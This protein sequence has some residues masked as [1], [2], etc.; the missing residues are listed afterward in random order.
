[1]PRPD[2]GYWVD[3][4]SLQ[5]SNEIYKCPHETCNPLRTTNYI[6]R[7][8]LVNGASGSDDSSCWNIAAY[9]D[10]NDDDDGS[11]C[12]SDNLI[13]KEGSRG[14]LCSSC[15]YDFTYS[16]EE[17]GCV[18]CKGS[19]MRVF[20]FIGI[21]VG[22][23][24]IFLGGLVFSNAFHGLILWWTRSKMAKAVQQVNSG[25]L[26]IIWANSQVC[27]QFINQAFSSPYFHATLFNMTPF[28]SIFQLQI[29]QSV[30]WTLDVSFPAPFSKMLGFMSFFSFDFI[31][32][33]CIIEGSTHFTK[34]LAWSLVPITIALLVILVHFT[35]MRV[36][37]SKVSTANLTFQ[38]LLLG[39]LILPP[40]TLKQLQALDCVEVADKRYL[41]VDTSIDCDSQ[42]FKSFLVV[43]S[44]FIT[45]Y[46]STPLIWLA[47][48]LF[49]RESLNPS[50]QRTD[51]G[52]SDK[53]LSLF[54]R[55]Q[56]KGIRPLF[57]LVGPYR[58]IYFFFEVIEM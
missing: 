22:T 53:K 43:N 37:G 33:E 15:D 8:L 29:V 9:S 35:R 51:G 28:F 7:R 20:V 31:S 55:D 23:T 16:P 34:V 41:R 48:L 12:N 46:L 6:Q 54:L 4:R 11:A 45:A 2:R 52:G 30:S 18:A 10:E 39:Y 42:E 1:M 40:V 3:R 24:I 17:R 21:L 13:C 5:F 58:Q 38:L 49:K 47:L 44:L 57:F 27:L 50:D 25:A 19:Q 14:A 32:L 26:K 56:D 36:S